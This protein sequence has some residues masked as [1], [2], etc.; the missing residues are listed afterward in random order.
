MEGPDFSNFVRNRF[1]FE[2][3]LFAQLMTLAQSQTLEA[4][5]KNL[6]VTRALLFSPYEDD[7]F[8]DD[9]IKVEAEHI[10]RIK[11]YTLGGDRL[12]IPPMDYN[13]MEWIRLMAVSTAMTRLAFRKRFYP[14]FELNQK[15]VDYKDV[16]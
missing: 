13:S 3:A 11:S 12:V 2:A 1:S 5:A 7:V 4:Y 10:E 16:K 14:Q 8:R 9:I 15:N 6:D